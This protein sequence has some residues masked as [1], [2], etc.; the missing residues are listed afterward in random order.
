MSFSTIRRSDGS[1]GVTIPYGRNQTYSFAVPEAGTFWYHLHIDTK[2]GDEGYGLLIVDEK[3]LIAAYDSE[4]EIILSDYYHQDADVIEAGLLAFG[5]TAATSPST[6]L[7][8]PG[9][10]SSPSLK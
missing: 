4:L 10:E 3:N 9:L 1:I 5:P 7:T 2:R 6:G 8:F